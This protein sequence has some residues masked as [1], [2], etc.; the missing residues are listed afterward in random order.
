LDTALD[1]KSSS[2]MDADV[3][4]TMKDDSG[5]HDTPCDINVSQTC[6]MDPDMLLSGGFLKESAIPKVSLDS[7]GKMN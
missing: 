1:K 3:P 6:E 4:S 2:L 7:M 5:T